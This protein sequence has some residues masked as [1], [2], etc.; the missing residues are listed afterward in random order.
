MSNLLN[1]LNIG[2]V[3][4]V[5]IILLYLIWVNNKVDQ[6]NKIILLSL[7]KPTVNEEI[8]LKERAKIEMVIE[9]YWKK[10][11]MNKSN[12]KKI[13]DDIK[14]G[15][16]RGCISGI[17]MGSTPTGIL[18]NAITVGTVSGTI[19]AFNLRNN[20]I[21]SSRFLIPDRFT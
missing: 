11:S 12:C 8:S 18:S 15:A 6:E 14:N 4:T 5:L 16:V 17:V 10:R 7:Y 3:L 13:F 1:E 2:Y 9:E 19:K 21:N 20:S